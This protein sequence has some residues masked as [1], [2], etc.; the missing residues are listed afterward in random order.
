MVKIEQNASSFFIDDLT[1]GQE[2][3]IAVNGEIVQKFNIMHDSAKI[4]VYV[5]K[6][7]E[8]FH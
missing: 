7:R 6:K 8:K 2:V 5:N 4:G 3:T 1:Y